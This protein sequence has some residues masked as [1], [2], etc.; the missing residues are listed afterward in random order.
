MFSSPTK[1]PA[2]GHY[3]TRLAREVVDHLKSAFEDDHE[4]IGLPIGFTRPGEYL[5]GLCFPRLPVAHEDFD[6]V[7]PQR[8]GGPTA[9]LIHPDL[10][11]RDLTRS[12]CPCS[13]GGS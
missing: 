7:Y 13:H 8:W 4:V 1:P 2:L 6:L 10:S 3:D 11:W 5:S 12:R 9:D